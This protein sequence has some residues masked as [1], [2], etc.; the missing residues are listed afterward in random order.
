M[1]QKHKMITY[2]AKPKTFNHHT[3]SQLI[4]QSMKEKK[5]RELELQPRNLHFLQQ[6]SNDSPYISHMD[7]FR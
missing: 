6:V 4:S 5:K 7:A 1:A 2:Q 3:R